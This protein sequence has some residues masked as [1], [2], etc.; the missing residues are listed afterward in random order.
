MS[1]LTATPDILLAIYDERV[2]QANTARR[3]SQAQ[4]ATERPP[5]THGRTWARLTS[6]ARLHSRPV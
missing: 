2:R 4:R 6:R 3:I 1:A 5:G